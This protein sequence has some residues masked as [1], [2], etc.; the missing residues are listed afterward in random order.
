MKKPFF[1]AFLENQL[2]ETKNV[3]GGASARDT[4]G[5]GMDSVTAPSRDQMQT[6]KY[7]SDSDE[8]VKM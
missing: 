6:M 3:K 4:T 1:A 7:P 5:R 2:N 8:T